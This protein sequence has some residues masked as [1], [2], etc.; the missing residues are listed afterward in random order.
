MGMTVEEIKEKA[1]EL[2]RKA[3]D[4][5]SIVNEARRLV[6]EYAMLGAKYH[7]G[8]T[9]FVFEEMCIVKSEVAEV[10]I[11]PFGQFEYRIYEKSGRNCG[12]WMEA[13]VFPTRDALCNRLLE[14]I[15]S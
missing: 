6:E 4:G 8:D 12:R 5:G 1:L 10:G 7:K 13:D 11:T 14:I 3:A 2:V 15:G 9:V